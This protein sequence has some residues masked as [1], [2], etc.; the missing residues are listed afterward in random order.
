[1]N[2]FPHSPHAFPGVDRDCDAESLVWHRVIT[3]IVAGGSRT[4]PTRNPPGCLVGAFK[5]VSTK[6]VNQI[7]GTS[8]GVIWF[9]TSWKNLKGQEHFA[10]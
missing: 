3:D 5:T 8:G 2:E 4:A 1:M 9:I 6:H 7:S 10:G